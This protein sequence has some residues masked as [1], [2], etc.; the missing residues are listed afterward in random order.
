MSSDSIR[1]RIIAP[2]YDEIPGAFFRKLIAAI[3]EVLSVQP[4]PMCRLDPRRVSGLP[5]SIA[6]SA[7]STGH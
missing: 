1:L 6:A 5:P 4:E 3:I 2:T 7:L